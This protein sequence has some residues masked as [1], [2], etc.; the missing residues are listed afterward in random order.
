MC[1]H[2]SYNDTKSTQC[3]YLN[4]YFKIHFIK[5]GC[6]EVPIRAA[7]GLGS[8]ANLAGVGGFT[9]AAGARGCTE[10]F[11]GDPRGT[12]GFGV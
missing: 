3:F 11:V 7:L 1:T 2:P 5:S 4:P 12:V 6:S 9:F 10:T 8:Y